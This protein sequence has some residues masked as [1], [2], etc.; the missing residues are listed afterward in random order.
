M[1]MRLAPIAAIALLTLAGCG[2][3]KDDGKEVASGS[4]TDG[5][6]REGSYSVSQNGD[7]A[8]IRVQGA[9]GEAVIQTGAGAAANLPKGFV[10]YPGATVTSSVSMAGDKQGKGGA[11]VS[12]ET[13]D[14][15]EKVAEFYKAAATKAG[16]EIR[17]EAS[18]AETRVISAAKD[19]SGGSFHVSINSADGK[20][21]GAIIAGEDASKASPAAQ[22]TE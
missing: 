19:A 15:A 3:S 16:Y 13:A 1:M 10:V 20:T 5:E 7:D 9:D 22:V 21:E 11:M 8:T 17:S 18:T 4:F 2:G 14:S 12:F 6:G